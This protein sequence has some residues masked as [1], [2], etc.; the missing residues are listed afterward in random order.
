MNVNR[1]KTDDLARFLEKN[2]L[3]NIKINALDDGM[4]GDIFINNQKPY[5]YAKSLTNNNGMFDLT[6]PLPTKKYGGQNNFGLDLKTKE[7][8]N[9][10][11]GKEIKSDDIYSTD[12]YSKSAKKY[13]RTLVN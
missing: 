9:M 13:K 10:K 3:D 6:N 7:Y 12:R 4:F 2:G 1:Y 11:T 5:N 8:V